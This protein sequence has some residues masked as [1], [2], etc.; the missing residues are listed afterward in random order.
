MKRKPPGQVSIT[1]DGSG[2]RINGSGHTMLE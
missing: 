2:F 1:F